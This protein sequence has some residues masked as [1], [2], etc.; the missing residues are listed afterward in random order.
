MNFASDNA[1]G[2][3]EKVIAAIIAANGG[4]MITAKFAGEQGRLIFAVP[5]R[6][7]Q[8]TSAGCHQLIRDGATLLTSLDDLLSELNYLDGLRPLAIPEK[9]VAGAVALPVLVVSGAT[10]ENVARYAAA[11]GIVVGSWVKVDGRW[12]MREKLI[13]PWN[14]DTVS[15]AGIKPTIA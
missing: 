3:S 5:G 1:S 15:A 8:N 10:A 13:D 2:A 11:D 14:S 12:L 7:D 6:I 4:A 9:A